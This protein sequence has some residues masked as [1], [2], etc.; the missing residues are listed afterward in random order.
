MLYVDLGVKAK[1][2]FN[3]VNPVISEGKAQ[4][5]S[6]IVKPNNEVSKTKG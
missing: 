5:K 3:V 1:H 2:N 6:V 4:E